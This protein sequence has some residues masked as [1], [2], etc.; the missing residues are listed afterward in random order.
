MY[1]L[2][3]KLKKLRGSC[4]MKH[5][6]EVSRHKTPKKKGL[7]MLKGIAITGIFL[8]HLIPS[9]FPGGFLGVPLFFVLSGYLMYN[10]AI[11]YLT[12]ET[13]PVWR[14]YKKRISRLLPPLFIMVMLVCCYM[15][16]FHSRQMIGIRPQALSIFL[17]YNNWW[18][19]SQKAS[20]F[21]RAAEASPFTHLWFL[22]VEI[23]FYLIWPLLFFLY[24]KVYL[25]THSRNAAFFFLVPALLSLAAMLCLYQPGGDPSRVYYGTDTMGF[26]ICLGM[27]L[28]ALRHNFPTLQKPVPSKLQIPLYSVMLLITVLLFLLVNGNCRYLYQGGMFGISIFFGLMILLM[29]NSKNLPRRLPL[30]SLTALVGKHSYSIYLWHYPVIILIIAG[31]SK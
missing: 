6:N 7:D 17:G 11:C 31:L 26:T 25:Y 2:V 27:F 20:Y 4:T 10:T 24:K 5:T 8:Y 9:V 18:Q 30:S 14:Y 1:S 21:T 13:F 3:Y 23:Q 19:I 29:E 16:L 22:G 15:T 28:G 12:D